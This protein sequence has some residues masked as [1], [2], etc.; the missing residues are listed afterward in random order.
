MIPF[1]GP[2][3]SKISFPMEFYRQ[4]INPGNPRHNCEFPGNQVD[5]HSIWIGPLQPTYALCT[6]DVALGIKV[7]NPFIAK[8]VMICFG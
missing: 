2:K 8:N 5:N 7:T 6:G 1:L 4:Q 3:T